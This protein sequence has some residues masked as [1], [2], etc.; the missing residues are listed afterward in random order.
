MLVGGLG[1]KL[2]LSGLIG[3]IGG[4]LGNFG[5]AGLGFIVV[6]GTFVSAFVP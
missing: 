5:G 6:G 2:A 3:L 1:S 4:K